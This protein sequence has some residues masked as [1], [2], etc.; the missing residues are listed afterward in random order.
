V[1]LL[2]PRDKAKEGLKPVK[3]TTLIATETNPP[4]GEKAIEWTLLTSVPIPDLEAALQ[5][6]QSYLCR[7]QIEFFFKILKSG[8]TIEKL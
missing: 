7:W 3:I 2:L 8:C 6:V 1:R 5:V 4:P